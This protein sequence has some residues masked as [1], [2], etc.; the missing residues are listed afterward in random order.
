MEADRVF[1]QSEFRE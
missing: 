1:E